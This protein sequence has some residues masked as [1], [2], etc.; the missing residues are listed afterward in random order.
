LLAGKQRGERLVQRD[1][2]QIRVG[3]RLSRRSWVPAVLYPGALHHDAVA[4]VR[5][6][7]RRGD[8]LD[9]RV[10][11]VI[12]PGAAGAPAVQAERRHRPLAPLAH[13][14]DVHVGGFRELGVGGRPS[15]FRL[16]RSLRLARLS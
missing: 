2:K 5:R 10:G 7:T 16:Q 11:A 14:R 1:A 15:Q 4:A 3:V 6:T 12:R 13:A 8:N 9:E